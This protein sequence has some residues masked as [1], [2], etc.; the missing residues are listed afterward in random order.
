MSFMA[1]E[2]HDKA[3][4][5]QQESRPNFE[6]GPSK[7]NSYHLSE[8]GLEKMTDNLIRNIFYR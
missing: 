3:Q 7:Y 2:N 4:T 5:E 6:Y 1:E 8:K